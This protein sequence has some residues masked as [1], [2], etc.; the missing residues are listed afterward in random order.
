MLVYSLWRQTDFGRDHVLNSIQQ[1][2]Q[3]LKKLLVGIFYKQRRDNVEWSEDLKTE[4][5]V[6]D[7]W[8]EATMLLTDIIVWE[9]FI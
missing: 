7:L 6:G 3:L 5:L 1:N 4:N 8:W 9:Q 2:R